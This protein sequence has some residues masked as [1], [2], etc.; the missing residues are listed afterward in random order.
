[1][2]FSGIHH[3]AIIC[4][5]Y[6]TSKRFYTELLGLPIICET[7][8]ADR[9]SYKLD[10]KIG[11][12]SAGQIELF[13]FPGPPKRLTRPEACG[14]RHLAF[15]VDNVSSAVDELNHKGVDTEPVRIDDLTGKPFTFF[16]DPD[17][18][19]LELYEK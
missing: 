6:Q 11:D 16:R 3:Y 12:G 9:D 10:L 5:D 13:S 4:S 1:M 15:A 2:Y 7:Y 18:L 17:D 8:R 14:L 19:P